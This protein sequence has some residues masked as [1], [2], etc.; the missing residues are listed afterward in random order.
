MQCQSQKE[1]STLK[2]LHTNTFRRNNK[3]L[4]LVLESTYNKCYYIDTKE[5]LMKCRRETITTNQFTSSSQMPCNSSF[6]CLVI[7]I[8]LDLVTL[9]SI[10][11]QEHFYMCSRVSLHL[12]QVRRASFTPISPQ[13]SHVCPTKIRSLI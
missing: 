9:D 7:L 3:V 12:P 11:F 4:Q 2:I 1:G 10:L 5:H 13:I 6:G 8:R